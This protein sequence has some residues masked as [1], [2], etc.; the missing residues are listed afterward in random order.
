MRLLLFTDSVDI[1]IDY[2]LLM[3]DYSQAHQATQVADYWLL[4]TDDW[5]L[6]VFTRMTRMDTE[7]R[8]RTLWENVNHRKLNGI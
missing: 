4:M 7:V 8:K 6:I 5:L 3:I 1:I 2:W